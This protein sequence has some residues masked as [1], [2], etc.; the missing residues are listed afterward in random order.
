[1]PVAISDDLDADVAILQLNDK[2]TP[3]HVTK[4]FDLNK[5]ITKNLQP[6]KSV[7]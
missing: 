6:Q 1:M 5:S 3:D 2:K 7:L 4:V